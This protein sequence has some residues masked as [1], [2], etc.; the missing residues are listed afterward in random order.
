MISATIRN[1]IRCGWWLG[2]T[3]IAIAATAWALIE[4]YLNAANGL[5][6][7]GTETKPLKAD[8]LLGAFLGVFLPDATLPQAMAL[9]I[10]LL[11]TLTLFMIANQLHSIPELV[12]RYRASRRANDH[13]EAEAAA[14]LL[15][16][17]TLG[18]LVPGCLLIY[19]I[20]WDIEIFRYRSMAGANGLDDAVEAAGTLPSWDLQLHENGGAAAVQLA[21][22]GAWGYLSF[23]AAG[24]VMLDLCIRRLDDA[25]ARLMRPVDQWYESWRAG[26]TEGAEAEVFYGYDQEGQPVYDPS[27]PIAYDTEGRPMEEEQPATEPAQGA[28]ATAQATNGASSSSNGHH[29]EPSTPTAT[30]EMATAHA[31]H[32]TADA[33]QNGNGAHHNGESN[34]PL[35]NPLQATQPLSQS[36]AQTVTNSP[37]RPE[38]TDLREVFGGAPGERVS[39]AEAVAHPDR[40]DVSVATGYVWRRE[41]R[42][43]LHAVA[44]EAKEGERS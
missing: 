6:L 36:A 33:A 22:I 23:T 18:M 17:Y 3:A 4:H 40:Y 30:P 8:S 15:I 38:V 10:S 27:V 7:A 43:E 26:Q 12:R 24:C 21:R 16:E 37:R 44:D 5:E 41:T 34:S 2:I 25:F 42:E 31:Y 1:I 11:E 13:E 20:L 19:G 32:A 29:K 35:F 9:T 14:W 39:L 28:S